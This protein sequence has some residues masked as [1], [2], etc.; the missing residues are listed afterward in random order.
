MIFFPS[1]TSSE[2]FQC[3]VFTVIKFFTASVPWKISFFQQGHSR[4]LFNTLFSR[5][6]VFHSFSAVKV[7]FQSEYSRTLIQNPDFTDRKF[8]ATAA[9]GK[10]LFSAGIFADAR[11]K[12]W[13][14]RLKILQLQ[15]RENFFFSGW[16]F[17]GVHFC[18]T[19]FFWKFSMF[20]LE[21]DK[22]SRQTNA[23]LTGAKGW[24]ER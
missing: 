7:L 15:Q 19:I 10:S 1:G 2:T 23:K 18:N 16:I 11:S 4:T 3:P 12:H 6:K 17:T 5:H 13:F 9:P 22:D 24:R 14:Y 21:H 20:Q 8:S